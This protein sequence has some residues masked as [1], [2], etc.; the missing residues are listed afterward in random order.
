M[1]ARYNPLPVN[2][3][4][5]VDAYIV[6][7]VNKRIVKGISRAQW[8]MMV[9]INDVLGIGEERMLRVFERNLELIDYYK[10]F[11]DDEVGDEVLTRRVK[12]ILPNTFTT[13]YP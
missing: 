13:L 6:S 1:K 7:E 11:E 5:Q 12:K 8:I 3:R 10:S 2:Q 4:K 9:S